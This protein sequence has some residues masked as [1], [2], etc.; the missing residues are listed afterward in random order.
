[1][2]N[3][4]KR[5]Q[6]R[7]EGQR[8]FVGEYDWVNTHKIFDNYILDFAYVSNLCIFVFPLNFSSFFHIFSEQKN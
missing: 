6:P 3:D 8:I 2:A 4:R 7:E 1:M 5:A